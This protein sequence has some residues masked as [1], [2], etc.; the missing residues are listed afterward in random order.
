MSSSRS[1]QQLFGLQKEKRQKKNRKLLLYNVKSCLKL[2]RVEGEPDS[3]CGENQCTNV[4]TLVQRSSQP[5]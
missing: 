1:K 4:P 5:I 2:E 3:H